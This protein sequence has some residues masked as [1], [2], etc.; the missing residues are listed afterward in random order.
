MKCDLMSD[1]EFLREFE[2]C[3]LPGDAFHHTEHVRVA[4]LYLGRYGVLQAIERMSG[5]LKQ[6]ASKNGRPERY[7]ETVTWAFLILIR[8]R[9]ERAGG[10]MCWEEFLAGN[11]DLLDWKGGVLSKYYRE[12][13]L[14]SELAKRIF[15]F[16]DRAVV[17]G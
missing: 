12:E 10:E 16:P 15:I 4:F 2:N 11:A 6:F 3:S 17:G 14:G 5:A 9:M 1:E 7:N 8:E 13:T